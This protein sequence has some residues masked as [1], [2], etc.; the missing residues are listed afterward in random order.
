LSETKGEGGCP[1]FSWADD[2]SRLSIQAKAKQAS[3]TSGGAQLARLSV[4]ELLTIC[5]THPVVLG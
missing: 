5:C 3:A 4:I 1:R 2:K